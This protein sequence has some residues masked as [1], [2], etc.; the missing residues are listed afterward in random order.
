M[1]WSS[2]GVGA[3][4]LE[5]SG[6]LFHACVVRDVALSLEKMLHRDILLAGLASAVLLGCPPPG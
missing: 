3:L 5:V 6:S 4:S 2:G 1:A